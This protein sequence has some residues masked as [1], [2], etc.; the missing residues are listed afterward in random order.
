MKIHV[1]VRAGSFANK[2]AV[3][4]FCCQTC[5]EQTKAIEKTFAVFS[6]RVKLCRTPGLQR[7][8]SCAQE[9]EWS[10]VPPLVANPLVIIEALPGLVGNCNR[11]LMCP[12][13]EVFNYRGV[14]RC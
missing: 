14:G 13:W 9:Y 11:G 8:G 6:R 7:Y 4:V 10:I 5:Q 3:R 2:H 1:L 12:Y